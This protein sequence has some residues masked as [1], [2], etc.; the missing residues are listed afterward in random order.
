MNNFPI[1]IL[2]VEDNPAEAMLAKLAMH[3]T[4]YEYFIYVATDGEKAMD[5]LRHE[6]E[7]PEKGL[8]D[9]ILLDLNLPMKSGKEVLKEIKSNETF[10]HIPLI[11]LSSSSNPRDIMECYRLYANCYITKPIFFDRLTEVMYLII[12]FWKIAAFPS[13]RI[14]T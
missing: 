6:H 4:H 7:A 5:Y 2:L 12:D 9:L 10:K 8:P 11:V 14:L 3:E 1:N 13:Q